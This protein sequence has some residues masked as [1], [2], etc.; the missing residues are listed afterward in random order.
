M[1]FRFRFETLLRIRKRMLEMA[2]ME[3]VRAISKRDGIKKE[4]ELL[5]KKFLEEKGELNKKM[6]EGI[7]SSE[8]VIRVQ[9]LEEMEKKIKRLDKRLKKAE[10]DVIKARGNLKQRHTD[11]ELIE[12]LRERALK[13]YLKEEDMRLQKE[14]DELV[15]LGEA[16]TRSSIK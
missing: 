11:C 10:I 6:G 16:R 4:L 9:L 1:A 13:E 14:L 8:F 7:M 5:E 3:F 12:N 2:Q 15:S